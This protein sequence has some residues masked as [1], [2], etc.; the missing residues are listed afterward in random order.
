MYDAAGRHLPEI[1]LGTDY[2]NRKVLAENG[3]TCRLD[4]EGSQA[5]STAAQSGATTLAEYAAPE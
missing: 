4:I 3:V 1:S 5:A 2:R